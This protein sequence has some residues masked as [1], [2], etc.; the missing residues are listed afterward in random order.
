MG[1]IDFDRMI[2]K[3]ININSKAR[4]IER[5]SIKKQFEY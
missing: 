4:E 1:G 2:E 5:E 3:R